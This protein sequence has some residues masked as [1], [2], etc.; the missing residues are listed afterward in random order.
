MGRPPANVA[1]PGAFVA[2]PARYTTKDL[3]LGWRF[4][5]KPCLPWG[6]SESLRLQ[7]HLGE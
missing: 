4:P 5:W 3:A 1:A 7:I 6:H 2:T